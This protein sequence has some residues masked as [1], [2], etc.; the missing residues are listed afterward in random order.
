MIASKV[1]FGFGDGPNDRGLGRKHVRD[2]IEGTFDRL[3][4]D[5]LDVYYIHRWDDETPIEETLAALDSLVETG[6]V[7]Y[8]GASTMAAWQFMKALATSDS[9]NYE[10]F[11]SM[12]PEY[13]LVSRHEEE[14]VLPLCR[15]QDVGVLPWSPLAGGFLTGKYSRDAGGEDGRL[16]IENESSM[17][18]RYSNAEWTVLETVREIAAE[19]DVT[20]AQVSIAWLLH[21]EVVTAPIIGPRTQ[22]HLD[23]SIDSL[24]VS[25]TQEEIDRLETPIS[26]AWSSDLT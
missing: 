6:K 26:P 4:T 14:N 25:L 12:Q 10:R 1:Y 24:E 16:T 19:R 3:G 17:E 18:D 22:T 13:S 9:E 2:R 11:V 5:Y 8:V 20:P 23:D 7:R 21:K 15:D